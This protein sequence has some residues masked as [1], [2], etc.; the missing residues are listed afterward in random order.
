MFCTKNKLIRKTVL[1][2]RKISPKC[3]DA[4]TST[5]WENNVS[6]KCF[7]IFREQKYFSDIIKSLGKHV[8]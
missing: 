1:I 7:S 6:P 5:E 2:I 8:L 3:K 4:V